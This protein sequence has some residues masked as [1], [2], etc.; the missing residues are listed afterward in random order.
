MH[1]FIISKCAHLYKRRRFVSLLVYIIQVCINTMPRRKDISTDLTETVVSACQPGK[2]YEA[3]SKLNFIFYVLIHEILE[4]KEGVLINKI[5]HI[6]CRK[7]CTF[8]LCHIKYHINRY[9]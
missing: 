5:V 4:L 8:M 9:L 3:F 6:K 7:T 2:G 1:S